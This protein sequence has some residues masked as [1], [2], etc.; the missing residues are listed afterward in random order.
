MKLYI[1]NAS[2]Q[3]IYD[4]IYTQIKA[5]I[6][7]GDLTPGEALPSIR[8]LAKDLRISVITTKRA[9]DELENEG[10]LYTVAGKGSFVAE[11]N[12]ELIREEHLKQIES[13]LQ[14]AVELAAACNLTHSELE[15]MLRI[16]LKED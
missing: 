13:C 9:Y 12:T 11:R 4:Q 16:L 7:S 1:S 2:G 6:I 10:F 15:E 8:S 5:N 14:R 3:P